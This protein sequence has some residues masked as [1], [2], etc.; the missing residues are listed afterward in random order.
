MKTKAIQL[1]Q[2]L[3]FSINSNIVNLIGIFFGSLLIALLAQIS[4]YV[5]F[6]PIPITGQ[7]VGILIIGGIL[8]PHKGF[9]SVLAYLGEGFLGFPVFTKMNSGLWVLLGPTGGYL[10]SFLPAV[11]LIGFLTKRNS[12]NIT[13]FNILSCFLVTFFILI[14][15]TLYLSFSLGLNK[16]FT[17]GFF[18]FILVGTIKSFISAIIISIYKKF[19]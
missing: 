4:I 16:A 7:T 8:G 6:S 2:K 17:M 19:S 10:L 5:P 9:L 11:F 15:G 13:V 1:K 14:I 18:P 12:L 3:I